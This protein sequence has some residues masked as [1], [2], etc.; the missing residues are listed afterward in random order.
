M[1]YMSKYRS[2]DYSAEN[3]SD[4]QSMSNL[5]RLTAYDKHLQSPH[6]LTKDELGNQVH[7]YVDTFQLNCINSAK[8]LSTRYDGQTKQW[9]VTIQTPTGTRDITSK[10]LVQATGFGSQKPYQPQIADSHLYK[11][12]SIHS[13]Q[14]KNGK[15]LR[16]KGIK[17]SHVIG[18]RNEDEGMRYSL[19]CHVE[20]NH[21]WFCQYSLRCPRGL[22][23]SWY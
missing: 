12:T 3:N 11:G 13:A 18:P 6:L 4:Q 17:V 14:F 8:V 7:K 20:C 10:Q 21:R 22:P 1:P 23:C 5:Q 2:P 16:G 15:E 19:T 9:T